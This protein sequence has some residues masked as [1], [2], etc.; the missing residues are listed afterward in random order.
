[1]AEKHW[2]VYRLMAWCHRKKLRVYRWTVWCHREKLGN[3]Q[4]NG[5]V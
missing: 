3:V 2:V 4:V 1:M 5:V